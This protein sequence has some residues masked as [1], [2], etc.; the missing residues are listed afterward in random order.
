MRDNFLDRIIDET[1][2]RGS[3]YISEARVVNNGRKLRVSN[4]FVLMHLTVVIDMM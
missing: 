2:G 3:C 4:D 1:C